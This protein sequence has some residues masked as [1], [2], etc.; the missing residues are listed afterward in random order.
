MYID[1]KSNPGENVGFGFYWVCEDSEG[2]T[3][4]EE[5]YLKSNGTYLYYIDDWVSDGPS[6]LV[7]DDEEATIWF[8]ATIDDIEQAVFDFQ[9]LSASSYYSSG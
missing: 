4:E 7:P 1:F 9:V 8:R 3:S 5:F 6:M 2:A